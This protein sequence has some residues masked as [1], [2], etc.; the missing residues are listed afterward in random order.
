MPTSK[1]LLATVRPPVSENV[2]V[3]PVANDETVTGPD[4]TPWTKPLAAVGVMVLANIAGKALTDPVRFE[5]PGPRAGLGCDY[6]GV[7]PRLRRARAR[8]THGITGRRPAGRY[9]S[10][11]AG[12]AL[13]RRRL[14]FLFRTCQGN[15]CDEREEKRSHGIKAPLCLVGVDSV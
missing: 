10:G 9:T 4:Q 1:E 15:D 3:T 7:R 6:P 2:R 12:R 8:R 5:Q 14:R 13:G 11:P